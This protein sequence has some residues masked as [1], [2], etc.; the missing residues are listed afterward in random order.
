MAKHG[1]KYR[2]RR[3]EDRSREDATRSTRRSSSRSTRRYAKFDETVEMA[4]RLG[5][6]PRQADQNVRG[7]VILPHGTGKTVR[8]LVFAKGDKVK[9]AEERRRRLRRAAK[10]SP[11][12]SQKRTGSTSTSSIATPDMMGAGRS[13]R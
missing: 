13:T 6:D 10:S 4:V 12:R 1:K 9:E 5:V 11:R 7:T 8:V 2:A 3:R